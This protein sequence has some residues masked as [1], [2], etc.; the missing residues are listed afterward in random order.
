MKQK[1]IL[2]LI[3]IFPPIFKAQALQDSPLPAADRSFLPDSALAANR[4]QGIEAMSAPSMVVA[5]G[6]YYNTIPLAWK[7]VAS[8]TL[9]GYDVYRSAL[10]SGPF[11]RV[12]NSIKNSYYRDQTVNSGTTYYYQIKSVY[13]NSF[14][15]FSMTASAK[16]TESGFIIQS[17]YTSSAP[18]VDG[19]IHTSEWGQA[20][21]VDVLYPGLSGVV[22][23]YVQNDR[24]RLYLAVDDQKNAVLDNWDSIGLF[25]DRDMDREWSS[26]ARAE[27]LIQVY[28]ENGS[29]K[30]RL[31][32][33]HGKWPDKLSLEGAVVL[34]G[35]TQGISSSSG[36]VQTEIAIDL[37][38]APFN[39]LPFSEM[40]FLMYAYDGGNGQFYGAWPQETVAKLP[41]IIGGNNWAYGPFSYGD[42]ILTLSAPA[43]FWADVDRDHDVDI[44]DIQ[45]VAGR[46]GSDRSSANYA[47]VYDVNSD[48]C[49]DIIDIQLVASWWNKPLPSGELIKAKAVA[50]APVR[51]KIRQVTSEKYEVWVDEAADLAAFQI[52]LQAD[53]ADLKEW[54][55][56]DFLGRNGNMVVAL[57]PSRD[58]ARNRVVVGAFSYGEYAG[59]GGSGKLAELG[60]ERQAGVEILNVTCA[61]KSGHE[62]AVEWKE[63][64]SAEAVLEFRVLPNHPNPF[65]AITVLS[66]SLPDAVEVTMSIYNLRGQIV[67]QRGLGIQQ[68]GLH[69]VAWD[70]SGQPSGVYFCRIGIPSTGQVIKLMLMR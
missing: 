28:W 25:Y 14:S 55:L 52:E 58:E 2:A 42:L 36:H 29:A 15:G 26:D 30:N 50:A 18:I 34:G 59:D 56:G 32:S 16:A 69:S 21:M 1:I 60:F 70:G 31:L 13:A 19:V 20:R 38:V 23:L 51:M 41:S 54:S 12:A 66:Y 8:D 64:S 44:I 61:D 67:E 17:P 65:N 27:G 3:L 22:R 5:L 40:G 9:L 62:L 35:I 57:P 37:R 43:N 6:G 10:A 24:N 48:G 7:P 46:W 53:G 39:Y 33:A 11:Y 4:W 49:I 45:L 63:S 68:A 47:A